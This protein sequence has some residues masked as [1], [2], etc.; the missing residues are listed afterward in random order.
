MK[1]TFD[2]TFCSMGCVPT[3]GSVANERGMR[4]RSVCEVKRFLEDFFSNPGEWMGA[5]PASADWSR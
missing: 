3:T 1:T 4:P 2:M 5:P